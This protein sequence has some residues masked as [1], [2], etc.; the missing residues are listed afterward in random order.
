MP[1]AKRNAR[2]WHYG[3]KTGLQD[4][5]LM[6]IWE[7]ETSSLL[8]TGHLS[9]REGGHVSRRMGLLLLPAQNPRAGVTFL[10]GPMGHTAP[11]T[12]YHHPASVVGPYTSTTFHPCSQI[13]LEKSSSFLRNPH[14]SQTGPSAPRLAAFLLSCRHTSHPQ[15]RPSASWTCS[16][17]RPS[18]R[19]EASACLC[20]L[21]P[22]GSHAGPV[23]CLPTSTPTRAST[24]S[25]SLLV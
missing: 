1:R 3:Q 14:P 13:R 10:K 22:G 6:D 16:D 2:K 21:H 5:T 12:P 25:A 18:D 24:G 20:L 8:G 11:S 15:K 4:W 23:G 17:F 9:P 7:S 19:R